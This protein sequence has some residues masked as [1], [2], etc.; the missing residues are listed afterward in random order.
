MTKLGIKIFAYIT[1]AALLTGTLGSCSLSNEKADSKSAAK[2]SSAADKNAEGAA[3]EASAEMTE[4]QEP[5]D[6]TFSLKSG[7]YDS[8]QQLELSADEGLKIYYTT[9]GSEPTVDSQLYTEPIKLEDRS[10]DENVLSAQTGISADGDYVPR[11]KVKKCNVIRAA[12]FD[13]NGVRTRI[14]SHSY[15]IGID[16]QAEYGDVPVISLMTDFDNL[17]DYDTGIYVLGKTHEEFLAE[18]PGNA[19]LDGWKQK[20]NYSNKGKEWERPM[21]V[22]YITADGSVGF[23]Q[24]MGARIMGAASR[25]STQKSFRLT[26]REEYGKKNVKYELIPDNQRSDGGGVVDKY[27]SFVLRNGG[28]DCN[29]AKLRDPFLQSFADGFDF[30]NQ[31]A[32]PCVVYL[33][34]EY[35]GMY[36]ITEDY[37]DNYIQNNYGIDK[38]NVVII[39]CNEIEEGEESDFELYTQLYDFVMN[40]DMTDSENFARAGEMIDLQ[41]LADYCAFNIYIY[42]QDCLFDDNNWRMWR[43]RE[44]DNSCEQADGKWR[45]M[46][47]DTDYSTGIYG[48]NADDNNIDKALT[49]RKS[50]NDKDVPPADIFRKLL[51]NDEFRQMLVISLC[52][53]RNITFGKEKMNAAL[54]KLDGVYKQIVPD[55]FK[56]FGPSYS[57]GGYSRNVT[58]LREF[59]EGRY[60]SFLYSVNDSFDPGRRADVTV[61]ADGSEKG[62]VLLNGDEL[63]LSRDFT[64]EYFTD[65][66]VTLTA[67][68]AE[69]S[70]FAGWE[71]SGC[72]V[73]DE[74]DTG[75]TVSFED[76][77]E[78]KAVFE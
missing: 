4:P 35:W 42:N 70:S 9:D 48:A 68:P 73:E 27:K 8:E 55:T 39:K 59:M 69:G 63:D 31:Q 43:V 77:C 74:T 40:S 57:V 53:M 1:A 21:T 61:K 78:I 7:F 17:F 13:E 37:N 46:L 52:D 72:T 62:R 28:N 18:K 54:D 76:A 22:D 25:N 30:E 20:G 56:R 15:F 33:D 23:T 2:S 11:T 26:A 29:Y 65:Y 34:G 50:L 41:G 3:E 32:T 71:Y 16:R 6:V 47:Y 24:D 45:M 38:E 12:A 60:E 49:K 36:S 66:P 10:G 51:D 75:I 64:G 58:S 67:E 14:C 5:E 19:R 44:P